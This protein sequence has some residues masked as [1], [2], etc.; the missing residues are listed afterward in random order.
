[1]EINEKI[2]TVRESKEWSQEEMAN[3]LS[4]SLSGYAK[5]ERGDTRLNLPKLE[6]IA[7][8]FE[9]DLI[10]LLSINDKGDVYLASENFNR[11][12]CNNI[13]HYY[14]DDR[15][16][17]ISKIERLEMALSLKDELLAQQSREIETLQKLVQSLEK[18]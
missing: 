2:R 9:M 1:M 15:R 10:E 6:K 7:Q 17:F 4:M 14:G 3:K 18:K 13:N 5:I 11:G 16:E 8:L 12:N